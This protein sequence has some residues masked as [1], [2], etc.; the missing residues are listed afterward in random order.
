MRSTKA[1]GYFYVTYVILWLSKIEK[2]LFCLRKIKMLLFQTTSRRACH[3]LVIIVPLRRVEWYTRQERHRRSHR[4]IT[5]HGR[6]FSCA[7]MQWRVYSRETWRF[8]YKRPQLLHGHA[9]E[10]DT[11]RV[12]SWKLYDYVYIEH[13]AQ[14]AY[15]IS[16]QLQQL[17]SCRLFLHF[18]I[19]FSHPKSKALLK[20]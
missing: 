20:I 8:N 15:L 1:I 3:V 18:S 12:N 5:R 7:R 13:G 10:R 4:W 16:I 6:S 14:I 19:Y 2:I 9:G 11:E 17:N